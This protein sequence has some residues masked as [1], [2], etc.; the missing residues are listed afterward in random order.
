M[1]FLILAQDARYDKI[2]AMQNQTPFA[3]EGR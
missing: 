2:A 3:R 1:L